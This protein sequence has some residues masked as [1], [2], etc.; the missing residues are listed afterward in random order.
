M[1]NKRQSVRVFQPPTYQ[2]PSEI[3]GLSQD[4]K[5]VFEALEKLDECVHYELEY[6]PHAFS[7]PNE[8]DDAYS[9]IRVV[10]F[11]DY[12][13]NVYFKHGVYQSWIFENLNLKTRS[14]ERD[15][16][17]LPKAIEKIVYIMEQYK[18]YEEAAYNISQ[19]TENGY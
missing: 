9:Y 10:L 3:K 13:F 5:V 15:K 1:T 4:E 8:D 16:G 17:N 7:E 11:D 18:D 6:Y 14:G 19:F 12:R 2:T